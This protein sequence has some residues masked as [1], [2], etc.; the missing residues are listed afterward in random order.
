MLGIALDEAHDIVEAALPRALAADLQHVRARIEDGRARARAAG[1]DDPKR[2]VAG[3]AR[4]VE[5][6]ERLGLPRRV[7][8]SDERI[9]PGAVQPTRHQ[10]VHEIV[11]PRH[12]A[13]HVVHELRLVG[14]R[15][16]AETEIGLAI[17]GIFAHAMAPITVSTIA[18]GRLR[19][20][21]IPGNRLT[22]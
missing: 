20:Y 2:D 21:Q 17:C 18:R 16:I 13:E 9:L 1:L 10:V 11:A 15:H 19:R 12:L 7:Y 3:A 8:R 22:E 14:E 6:P 5:Q 4:H